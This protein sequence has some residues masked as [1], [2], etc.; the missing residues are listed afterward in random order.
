MEY[1]YT[2]RQQLMNRR[3]TFIQVGARAVSAPGYGPLYSDLSI[4][5]RFCNLSTDCACSLRLEHPC[6]SPS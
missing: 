4:A 3:L 6:T 2:G 5:D 1:T